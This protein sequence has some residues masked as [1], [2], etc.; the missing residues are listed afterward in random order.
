METIIYTEL[1][2][3]LLKHLD[4]WY[5]KLILSDPEY[6]HVEAWAPA[7]YTLLMM[8]DDQWASI[9]EIFSRE[10]KVG[11][12]LCS[13]CG[14]SGVMTHPDYR[15]RGLS[16]RLMQ[17]ALSLIKEKF[18]V[19]F[20]VLDCRQPLVDFYARQG[21]TRVPGRILYQQPDG[22]KMFDSDRVNIMILPLK[23]KAWENGDLDLCGLPW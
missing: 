5:D 7:D 14:I 8:D 10:I 21:F 23:D 3:A 1:P 6:S 4:V 19:D 22:Q 11:G 2:D 18:D 9:M 20:V 12:R 13:V 16:T 15:G 17:E